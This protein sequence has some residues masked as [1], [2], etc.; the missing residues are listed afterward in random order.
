M[1]SLCMSYIKR[2]IIVI[3]FVSS[4]FVTPHC[5]F[6]QAP[7]PP[8]PPGP[9]PP[10]ERQQQK[11][12]PLKK[13]APGVFRL[14]DIEIN[15]NTKSIVFPAL[16]NMDK[17]LLEYILV[18]TGGKT[19]ESLF[20]TQVQP[21]DL[22]VAFLLLGFEGTDSP[23][24]FQGAQEKPKGDPIAIT[25]T[26]TKANGKSATIYPE[27][28]IVHMI[29][30]KAVNVKKLDWV[31]TGSTLVN[32]HFLAQMEGSIIAVYHDPVAL[33]DNASEGGG[34]HNSWFVKEGSVPPV[35][36]PVTLTI[37]GKK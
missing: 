5:L 17:G 18:R 16:I 4:F 24:R 3:F 8:P 7:S 6:A 14:G 31:F 23:L 13:V 11:T 33:I 15:K 26:Y 36:T 34:M 10:I 2:I 19:H 12:T 35:G 37:R 21:Y 28:W 22:Q 9:P 27:E 30:N 25:I 29:E 32:G 20:R 1:R